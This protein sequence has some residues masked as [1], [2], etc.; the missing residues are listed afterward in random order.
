MNRREFAKL[1]SGLPLIL[2]EE[3]ANM[4]SGNLSDI[5]GIKVG[6]YESSQ[7]PTGCTVILTPGGAV[8]GV[9]VRG[10]APGTR[11][12]DLLNPINS[13]DKVHAILLS[14][15]SA[16]GL[17]AAEGVVRYLEEK[18]IGY[19][20]SSALVPIV[21]AAILYDLSLGDPSIRP[22]AEAGYQACKNAQTGPVREGNAGAGA[23][24]TVGKLFGMTRAMKGGLGTCS[25]Q[26]GQLKV[27]AL[28]AVNCIGDVVDSRSGKIL[29]GA[30]DEAGTTLV[31]TMKWLTENKMQ[32]QP[33]IGENTTLGVVATNARFSKA[34]MTK[35]A[36][37]AHDGLARSINPVHL[38]M[39]G[40][41]IFALSTGTLEDEAHLTQVG[42]LAAWTIEKAV[43]RA[44]L[45]A[46]SL[47]GLPAARDLS[48]P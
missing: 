15:G 11:E 36:Q 9:D 42:S 8:A 2:Q 6:H 5:D 46:T 10:S 26:A 22:N 35:V 48:A 47:P 14:G 23:G 25:I 29:A 32:I 12:T 41:T 21:P 1:A 33:R 37:M 19:R 16:F 18:K 38:P 45:K 44:V 31:D 20:T 40:D 7:R 4:P 17:S 28:V 24:A 43:K 3:E 30:R 13:V 39:D 34:A 27:A